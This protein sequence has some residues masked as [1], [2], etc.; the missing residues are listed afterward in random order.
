MNLNSQTWP[1]DNSVK[2]RNEVD[3]HRPVEDPDIAHSVQLHLLLRLLVVDVGQVHSGVVVLVERDPALMIHSV[4][5]GHQRLVDVGHLEDD[6]L[7]VPL[8]GLE[9]Q[10]DLPDVGNPAVG[11]RHVVQAAS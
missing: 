1:T 3:G 11:R 4:G 9:L 8:V 2:L 5:Y 10:A 6:G 7:A